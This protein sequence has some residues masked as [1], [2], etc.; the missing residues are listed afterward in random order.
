MG[1]TVS[2]LILRKSVAEKILFYLYNHN[3]RKLSIMRLGKETKVTYCSVSKC[4]KCL[5]D[6]GI[7]EVEEWDGRTKAVKLTKKGKELCVLLN[8]F[9]DKY[10]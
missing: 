2:D 6:L 8:N 7:L 4:V 5:S 9:Y 1:Q 10:S 3:Y